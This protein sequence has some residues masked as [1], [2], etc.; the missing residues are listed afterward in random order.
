MRR[1]GALRPAGW[2]LTCLLLALPFEPRWPALPLLGLRFTLLECVAAGATLALA[3]LARERLARLLRRPPLPAACLVAFALAHFVSAAAAPVNGWTAAVYSMRMAAAALLAT[4]VAACEREDVEAGLR[5]I[6]PMALVV[7]GVAM[8]ERAGLRG[9][10][11]FLDAFRAG[12]YVFEGARR[13]SATTESPNLA[14]SLLAQGLVAAAGFA[15]LEPRPRRVA[16]LLALPLSVGLLLTYSRGGLAAALAGVAVVA[17]ASRRDA[18]SGARGA[19]ASVAAVT[20][21]LVL[22]DAAVRQRLLGGLWGPVE[23]ARYEPL[24]ATLTLAPGQTTAVSLRVENTGSKAWLPARH[25]VACAW[26]AGGRFLDAGCDAPLPAALAPGHSVTL[27]ARARAPEQE[28]RYFLVWNVVDEQ[29]P[30]SLQGVPPGIVPALVW[31]NGVAPPAPEPP[32]IVAPR[33]RLRLWKV[34]WDMW[35]ERPLLGFGPD[36]F[37]KLHVEFRGWPAERA[38]SVDYAHSAYLEAA[39]SSG[40]LALATLLATLVACVSRGRRALTRAALPQQRAAGAVLLGAVAALA[41]HWSVESLLGFTAQY[42]FFGFLVGASCALDR[43]PAS[44]PRA[45]E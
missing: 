3:W 13:A 19:L 7:A 38:G 43:V 26:F 18:R 34:A 2:I 12:P 42:V 44:A 40:G 5:A 32:V 28:G 24:D 21:L 29:G 16:A 37:R 17:L 25:R 14:A 39:A 23:A 22:G 35:R 11:A 45:A 30:F 41:V 4:V 10:D 20:A 27:N 33:S 15:A 9:L 8:L 31:S 36:N 6:V 1:S